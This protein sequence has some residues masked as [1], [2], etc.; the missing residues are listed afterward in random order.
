MDKSYPPRGE[1]RK[2]RG[3]ACR[4]TPREGRAGCYAKGRDMCA[5]SMM[6]GQHEPM[7]R[8]AGGKDSGFRR[9]LP[10]WPPQRPLKAPKLPSK[11]CIYTEKKDTKKVYLCA[12]CAWHHVCVA[13]ASRERILAGGF[14][15]PPTA[16]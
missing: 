6:G 11:E 8:I 5:D 7:N 12:G 1:G 14:F 4:D 10:H 13:A 3:S 16:R 2:G 9:R 15:G